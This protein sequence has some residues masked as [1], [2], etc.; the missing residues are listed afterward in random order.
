[1]H[2]HV[3][4]RNSL[5]EQEQLRG[6]CVSESLQRQ[7][8]THPGACG[9]MAREGA[10]RR[11]E[12]AEEKVKRSRKKHFNHVMTTEGSRAGGRRH[13]PR[14]G[15]LFGK[16]RVSVP[17]LLRS[18]P[19]S[20]SAQIGRTRTWRTGA[21]CVSRGDDQVPGLFPKPFLGLHKQHLY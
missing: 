19:A 10:F 3:P 4:G 14:S 7:E 11:Q 1:M 6:K 12:R 16:S 18:A 8:D 20:F 13:Y 9:R 17:G 21:G 2:L 5:R 15:P